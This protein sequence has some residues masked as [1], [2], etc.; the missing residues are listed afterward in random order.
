[1]RGGMGWNQMSLGTSEITRE[2]RTEVMTW[3]PI[4][5]VSRDRT[6]VLHA[7]GISIFNAVNGWGETELQQGFLVTAKCLLFPSGMTFAS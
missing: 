1:M 2:C 3:W 6:Q 7:Y 5:P 4:E